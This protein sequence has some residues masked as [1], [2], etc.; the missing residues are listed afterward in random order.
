VD[1]LIAEIA[2][3]ENVVSARVKIKDDDSARIEVI[4]LMDDCFSEIITYNLEPRT[5]LEFETAASN[6]IARYIRV[7]DKIVSLITIPE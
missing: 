5:T 6:M 7:R 1:K 3:C 2:D 4:D